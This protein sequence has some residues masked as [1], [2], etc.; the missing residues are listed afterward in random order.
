VDYVLHTPIIIILL[1]AATLCAVL[2]ALSG[3]AAAAVYV[4]ARR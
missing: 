2:G 3:A 1:H 4:R